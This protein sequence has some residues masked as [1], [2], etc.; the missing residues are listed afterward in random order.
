LGTILSKGRIVSY[1]AAGGGKPCA[2]R[3]AFLRSAFDKVMKNEGFLKN[4]K[5]RFPVWANTWTGQQ[6]EALTNKIAAT[7]KEDRLPK[8]TWEEIPKIAEHREVR[9]YAGP[10]RRRLI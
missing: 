5:L 8:W 1:S 3:L 7:S 9:Q 4:I 2:D 10:P 6:V